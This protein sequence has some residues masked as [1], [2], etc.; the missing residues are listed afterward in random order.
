MAK[1]ET[2]LA[3]NLRSYKAKRMTKERQDSLEQTDNTINWDSCYLR[4]SHSQT[5]KAD[6]ITVAAENS[7]DTDSE[8]VVAASH[9]KKGKHMKET[10]DNLRN[11]STDDCSSPYWLSPPRDFEKPFPNVMPS[12]SPPPSQD[13][14]M[15]L[16]A[17][18]IAEV[19][20]SDNE[21]CIKTESL[22][23]MRLWTEMVERTLLSL[24]VYTWTARGKWVM[25][26]VI[27]L[28]Y[29]R[30]PLSAISN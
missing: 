27:S 28:Y 2:S 17:W 1:E 8:A 6:D 10:V 9:T 5:K 25:S 29:R 16:S 26:I 13:R 19:V 21:L 23:N 22:F 30:V 14:N 20:S 7:D 24:P 11:T 18:S 12:S 3:A 15:R 4:S